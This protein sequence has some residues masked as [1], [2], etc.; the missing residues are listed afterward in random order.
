[1]KH[2]PGSD[3]LRTQFRETIDELLIAI[4]KTVTKIEE[5]VAEVQPISLGRTSHNPTGQRVK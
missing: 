5:A 4:R 2:P 3:A 1:M